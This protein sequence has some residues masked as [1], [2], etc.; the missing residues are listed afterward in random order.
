MTLLT[1][2]TNQRSHAEMCQVGGRRK[3]S[4]LSPSHLLIIIFLVPFAT[5]KSDN[6][7]RRSASEV[8]EESLNQVLECRS[9]PDK[10][11][12]ITSSLK[13]VKVKMKAAKYDL[14]LPK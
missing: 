8:R 7:P 11:Y 12:R 14:S 9:A 10:L 1:L 5:K 3:N 13:T 2:L 4:R 6:I